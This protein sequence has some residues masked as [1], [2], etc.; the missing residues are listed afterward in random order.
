MFE[1]HKY[2]LMILKINVQIIFAVLDYISIMFKFGIQVIFAFLE[3]ILM[4]YMT[5]LGATSLTLL[6][7]FGI[8]AQIASLYVLQSSLDLRQDRHQKYELTVVY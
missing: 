3:Y 4:K 2:N 6:Y 1:F 8:S 7:T 5:T